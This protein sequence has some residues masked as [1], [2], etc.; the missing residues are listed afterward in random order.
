M[1]ENT[2]IETININC[3]QATNEIVDLFDAN[4]DLSDVTIRKEFYS[5]VEETIRRN[6]IGNVNVVKA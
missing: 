2:T 1:N 3:Q 5:C 6:I 4:F